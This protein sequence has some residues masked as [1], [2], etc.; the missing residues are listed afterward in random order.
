MEKGKNNMQQD[1]FII[2]GIESSAVTMDWVMAELL[3]R[4]DAI[5]AATDKLDRVNVA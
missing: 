4:P 2:G 1:Y 3:Q 5:S